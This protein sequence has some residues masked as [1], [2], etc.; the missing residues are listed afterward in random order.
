[1]RI[2]CPHCRSRCYTRSSRRPLPV[3]IESYAQCTNA[4]CGWAG[5]LQ[6]E[7][8]LTTR[9]SCLPSPDVSIPIDEKARTALLEQLGE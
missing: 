2:N 9:P 3:F 7:A 5:K 6:T 1:M 4:E 8:V